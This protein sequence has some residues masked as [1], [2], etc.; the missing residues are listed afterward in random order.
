MLLIANGLE[1]AALL[2]FLILVGASTTATAQQ[3]QDT[4]ATSAGLEEVVVTARRRSENL[5]SV[6]MA[7]DAFD[8]KKIA[9]LNLVR[10]GDVA[11][12]TPNLTF[13]SGESG[14][15]NTPIIR[16]MAMIDSRGFDNNVGVFVDGVYVSGRAAQDL[17]LLD[18]ERIEVV[19]GPQSALYGRNTFAGAI[20]FVS[21]KPTDT[22]ESDIE[23]T[24]GEDDL[25]RFQGAVSGPIVADKLF[26]RLSVGY[27]SDDGTY[28]NAGPA[29][30]GSGIDGF[31]N[32]AVNGTLYFTPSD[33]SE[34][35][36]DVYW[37]EDFRA[38]TALRVAPNNCG[39]IVPTRSSLSYDVGQP[40]YACGELPAFGSDTLSLSPEAYSADG[41][42][43]KIALRMNFDLGNTTLSSITAF[44]ENDSVGFADLD[45]SQTGTAH[46]GYANRALYESIG[47]P[48]VLF[49]DAP[50][51]PF[52]FVPV[53]DADFNTYIGSQGL[54]Q[55]YWS[56]ELRLDSSG[57]ERLRWSAGLFYFNAE[58]RQTSD[59]AIDVSSAVDATGLAP[60]QLV[61][62]LVDPVGGGP[63][64]RLALPHPL[65][66]QPGDI[67]TDL[68][69]NN[70]PRVDEFTVAIEKSKQVSAFASIDYDISD[71][72]TATAE[73]RWTKETRSL[74]DI[75]D[76]FFFTVPPGQ[77]NF[78]E[79]DHDWVDPRFTLRY[80]PSD[81]AMY[82]VSA[83]HGTRSGGVNG[84]TRSVDADILTFDPEENWTYEIGAKTSWADQKLQLNA[85]IFYVD[86]T[87]AQF[88]Q[89][90]T[91]SLGAFL[92]ATSNA[93]GLTS[94]GFELSVVVRPTENFDITLGY[95][96][97]DASFDS[98][99]LYSGGAAL[100]AL[101]DPA[102]SNYPGVGA[103]CVAD[104]AGSG[105]FF[106][107]I[108][109]LQPRRSSDTTAN[110]ALNYSHPINNNLSFFA[111]ANASYR[112][113]QFMDE[114]NTTYVPERV[115][116]NFSA[117]VSGESF[118]VTLWIKNAFDEDAPDFA[119]IFQ[120][121]LNSFRPVASIVGIPRRRIGLTARFR[122]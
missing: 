33:G 61:F 111:A 79:V 54:D 58:N 116:S 26:G 30:A 96:Y 34:I 47:S 94:K 68:W 70:I 45:R 48:P 115:I 117:G 90:L 66:A 110:L 95:G 31:E 46:W 107:D 43:S 4:S 12:Q 5:Q 11:A 22:F 9:E 80:T 101:A 14:R 21:K 52:V 57:S 67:T 89:R 28:E 18:L 112:S 42:T 25:Q 41:E 60:D 82:Y 40:Y 106:P 86:W 91:D 121:D 119:Q 83:A 74:E 35:F 99:T 118:D 51:P 69:S 122:F 108:S 76:E 93:T 37:A 8:A 77:T 75:K 10:L 72:L 64:G 24:L 120:S 20:N 87:D 38:S 63:L 15:L 71:Q 104:P 36:L 85:A 62:M 114:I 113:K 50:F 19:K 1:R 39:E 29:A 44:T 105:A 97:S 16:G 23:L 109:G 98:G 92:T 56:Q 102:T 32:K 65:F 73:L 59:F 81:K 13:I 103:V 100:C 78:F 84:N 88:R 17:T 6:P 7:V 27:L 53:T 49:P 55:E 3:S 2:S